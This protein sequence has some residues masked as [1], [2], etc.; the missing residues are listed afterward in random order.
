MPPPAYYKEAGYAYCWGCFA[1]LFPEK[2]KLKVKK[3]HFLAAE[4]QRRLG[5]LTADAQVVEWDCP[6]PGGCSLKKP[7]LLIVWPKAYL[8]FE[9][10]EHGHAG[11]ECYEE[12]ARLELIADVGLPGVVVRL[13]PDVPGYECFRPRQLNNGEFALEA[14]DRN[15]ALLA[16][17]AVAAAR[18]LL[19]TAT[20]GV[21]RVFVDSH[22]D[23]GDLVAE[24]LW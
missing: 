17:R 3:E 13:N 4:L 8:H 7:G 5:D 6:V 23:R 18:S 9:I 2:A 1:A 12:G 10:D 11:N 24:R 22:P 15:F 16:D 14:V 19:Q 20:S 21:Q